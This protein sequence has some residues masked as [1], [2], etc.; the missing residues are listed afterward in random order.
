MQSISVRRPLHNSFHVLPE[1]GEGTGL[2]NIVIFVIV[3]QTIDVAPQKR[4]HNKKEHNIY[5]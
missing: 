2:T 5:E 4:C 1:G 3:N